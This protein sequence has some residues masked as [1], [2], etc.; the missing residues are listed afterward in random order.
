MLGLAAKVGFSLARDSIDASLMR[1]VMTFPDPQPVAAKR[2]R[3]QT[4]DLA[5]L[6]A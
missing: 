6:P 1:A 2:A 4:R 5:G 3:P